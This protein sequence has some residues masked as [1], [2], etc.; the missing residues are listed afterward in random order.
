M[1]N[2]LIAA[3][4]ILVLLAAG[5]YVIAQRALGGDLVRSQIE[6]QLSSR[7]GQ[8]V[9]I[10]SASADVFPRVAIDLHDFSIGQPAAVQAGRVRLVTG[11]RGL[12]SRRVED[13]AIIIEDG[14]ATW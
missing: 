14:R 4:G 1:R 3:L 7:L 8:P 9:H 13:A 11:L 10:K 2:R 5:A 6:Q 12:L